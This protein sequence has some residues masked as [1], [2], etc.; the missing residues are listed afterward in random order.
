MSYGK[1]FRGNKC[2]GK[3]Q[4]EWDLMCII[5]GGWDLFPQKLNKTGNV[6][7]DLKFNRIRGFISKSWT[8]HCKDDTESNWNKNNQIRFFAVRKNISMEKRTPNNSCDL[9]VLAL[10][11]AAKTSKKQFLLSFDKTFQAQL[12]M[13]HPCLNNWYLFLL[14]AGHITEKPY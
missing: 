6:N 1:W 2:G 10:K 13:Q 12:P 4:R 8:K 5:L 11:K 14:L 7:H 3:S 9:D